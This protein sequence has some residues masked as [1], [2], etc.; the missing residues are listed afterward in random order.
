M[1]CSVEFHL[2]HILGKF[3]LT[4]PLEAVVGVKEHRLCG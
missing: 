4:S 3:G 2:G 1:E